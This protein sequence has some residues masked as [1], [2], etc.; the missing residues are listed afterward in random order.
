MPNTHI[1]YGS[2]Q[3]CQIQSIGLFAAV[4]Q[5]PTTIGRLVG[6][7][8]T[9]GDAEKTIRFQSST[10]MP[11]VRVRDLEKKAGDEVTFDLV[12]PIN[13]KPIMGE[14]HAEGLGERMSFSQD[15]LRIDQTRKP[16]SA[17]GRMTQQRTPHQ[18][19]P[20]ARA[21]GE[22]YMRR[23]EDQLALVH[24]AGARGF[25]VD[26]EWA[27]PLEAD[28]D[29]QEIVVNPIKAPTKN[30]H[31][32]A[33]ADSIEPVSATG[34][35]IKINTTDLLT[36][37]TVDSLRSLLDSMALAPPQVVFE[38]DQA[39]YDAP[40]RV[41]LVSPLQYKS[42]VQSKDFRLLQAQA[43]ARAQLAKNNPL[44]LGEVGL[45]NGILIVKMPK[46]IRFFPGNA[47]KY[48]A[49]K[50]EVETVTDKVPTGGW[51]GYAVDRA[52]LLGGQS[53][54]EAYG[55]YATGDGRPSG[56]PYFW[57]EE[58]LDHK[59]KLEVLIGSVGGKSKIRFNIDHGAG[60]E[61]TDYGVIAIDTA[62]KLI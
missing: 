23:F 51:D 55:N 29:F 30:R 9:Q 41:L 46:A 28:P 26:A 50:D 14:R 37:D 2:P 59:D 47:L 18:L 31:F 19:R 40:I 32:I 38:G 62:V 1:P 43:M 10:E 57:N 24:M 8:P 61:A 54:A 48:C 44:F 53:L 13:G 3:A 17:G 12:N 49:G 58:L 11:I 4:M 27:I 39:A 33:A 15:R 16:I 52:I 45:W 34:G 20:L 42:L 56:V 35:E 6:K 36:I 7:M 25:A 22:N 5:R 21:L 60:D